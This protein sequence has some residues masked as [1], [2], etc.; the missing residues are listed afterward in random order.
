MNKVQTSKEE[1]EREEK[2]RAEE[3]A[4]ML[5]EFQR[6]YNDKQRLEKA[7]TALK[8]KEKEEKESIKTINEALK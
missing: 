6:L 2:W 8:N 4:R 5:I 7:K 1:K 3:D